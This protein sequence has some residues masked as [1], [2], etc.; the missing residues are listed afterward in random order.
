MYICLSHFVARAGN[1]G[2]GVRDSSAGMGKGRAGWQSL[3]Q[4]VNLSQ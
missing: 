1:H 3:L 4:E 2:G